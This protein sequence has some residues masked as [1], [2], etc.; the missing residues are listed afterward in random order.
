MTCPCL[1]AVTTAV[2]G[3]LTPWVETASEL[4]AIPWAESGRAAAEQDV[5]GWLDAL[6]PV[7]AAARVEDDA[8]AAAAAAADVAVAVGVVGASTLVARV[9][10]SVD[11]GTCA[12]AA[13]ADEDARGGGLAPVCGDVGVNGSEC[14]VGRASGAYPGRA[15]AAIAASLALVYAGMGVLLLSNYFPSCVEEYT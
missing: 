4:V 6:G 3:F 9:S 10:W 7:A 13:W 5:H 11:S 15:S 8:S 14:G 1:E 12:V 2:T